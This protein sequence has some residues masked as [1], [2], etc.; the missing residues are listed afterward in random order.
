MASDKSSNDDVTGKRLWLL[1][2]LV[3]VLG[4]AVVAWAT[5]QV[6][7]V[8][9]L[10]R[11]P[12]MLA[13]LVAGI[14]VASRTTV[15]IRLRDNL[16]G[17]SWTELAVIVGLV[18]VPTPWVILCTAVAITVSKATGRVPL[19]R[20]LFGV[21]KEI[22]VAATAAGVF[23]VAGRPLAPDEVSLDVLAFA[24]LAMWMV[25][26][27][28]TLPVMALATRT[29]IRRMALVNKQLR[30]VGL[31]TRYV[32]TVLVVSILAFDGDPRLLVG[33]PLVV[34]CVHLWQAGH[35]R[36]EQERESWQRLA[37]TTDELNGV[38]L[39]AVLHAAATRAAQLVAAEEAERAAVPAQ[40]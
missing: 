17:I 11:H 12:V 33:V 8:P 10:A 6:I 7:T 31:L 36:S 2:G 21:G 23:L 1:I 26:E 38:D 32:A 24:I 9:G 34:L 3:V 16:I 18:I 30:L 19:Q 25:D 15:S 14:T 40:P 35:L 4:A 39:T 22:L 29:P 28:L 20:S 27:A 13:L 5:V 37:Q